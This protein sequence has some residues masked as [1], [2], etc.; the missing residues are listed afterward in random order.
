VS[1]TV[2]T[3]TTT[4]T[5]AMVTM[6]RRTARAQACLSVPFFSFFLFLLFSSL[7]LSAPTYTDR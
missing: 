6:R 4:T 7:A 5:A 3:T 2:T 1:S